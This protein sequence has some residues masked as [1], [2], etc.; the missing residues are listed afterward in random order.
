MLWEKLRQ[1]PSDKEY[2]VI[3]QNCPPCDCRVTGVV[4]TWQDSPSY[5]PWAIRRLRLADETAWSDSTIAIEARD[6]AARSPRSREGGLTILEALEA[7]NEFLQL[8]T[9]H[10][11]FD[12][13]CES[14]TDEETWERQ[15]AHLYIWKGCYLGGG[16]L[17]IKG[18]SGEILE[19][20]LTCNIC[21][22]LLDA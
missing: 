11:E 6:W 18:V 12:E 1:A 8:P 16:K 10:R 17:G 20:G 22:C 21:S 4:F 2:V 3:D 13:R 5:R 9:N 15:Y 7:T 14:H 19:L